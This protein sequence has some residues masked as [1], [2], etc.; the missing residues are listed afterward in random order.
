MTFEEF[1]ATGR[2]SDDLTKDTGL[3]PEDTEAN[4]GRIYDTGLWIEKCKDGSFSTIVF[5]EQIVSRSLAV[6]EQFLYDRTF[7]NGECVL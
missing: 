3:E 2:D 5:N 1:Q 6:V 7:T 4:T